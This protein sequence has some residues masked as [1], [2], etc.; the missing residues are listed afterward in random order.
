LLDTVSD[1]STGVLAAYLI[2]LPVNAIEA[3]EIFGIKKEK[4]P[5]ILPM[6]RL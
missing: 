2:I 4:A 3:N 1:G 6:E 5:S